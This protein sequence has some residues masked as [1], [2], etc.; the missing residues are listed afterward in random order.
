MK[1]NTIFTKNISELKNRLKLVITEEFQPTLAIIFLAQASDI[2]EVTTTFQPYN[3]QVIGTTTAGE[4]GN[5]KVQRGGISVLLLDLDPTHFKIIHRPAEYENS[6][7][8][9]KEVGAQGK[10][11]FQNPA[12]IMVFSMKING[13]SLVKGISSAVGGY[14]PIFGGMAGDNMKMKSTHTFSNKSYADNQVTVLVLNNDKISV[15]GM[16]LCGWQPIGL[17]N[18]ITKATDNIIYEINDEPALN[19]VKRYFGEYYANSL[20]GESVPLG[21]AQYPLQIF[22]NNDY[23]LRAALDADESNGSLFM[24]GPVKQGDVFRFSV[25]PGFE[26]IDETVAGFK[27]YAEKHPKADA[28]IMFSCVARHMSLGPMIEE[29]V[30]GIYNIWKKPMAGFFSYGEV[31]QQELGTSHFYNE[32]CSLVLLKEK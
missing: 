30:E 14:P 27:S 8:I 4:I 32:T 31:G 26:V 20:D 2:E 1:S 24:A 19:V 10:R 17:E 5:A 21:A 25:A 3:I 16:A 12:F 13:E 29:E 6:I 28:L 9:G 22:R 7:E 18:K 23:V 11:I 15:E